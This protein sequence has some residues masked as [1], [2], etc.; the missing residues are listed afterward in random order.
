MSGAFSLICIN[1]LFFDMIGK[2]FFFTDYFYKASDGKGA[3]QDQ[4]CLRQCA[5][6]QR[7]EQLAIDSRFSSDR[8]LP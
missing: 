6:L 2:F 1:F 8:A 3:A 5:G 7:G 4:I